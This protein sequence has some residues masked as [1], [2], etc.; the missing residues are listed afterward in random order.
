MEILEKEKLVGDVRK[1]HFF[2]PEV[3]FW[4]IFRV[5]GHGDLSQES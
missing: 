5:E 4:D 2:I 3:N 1:V